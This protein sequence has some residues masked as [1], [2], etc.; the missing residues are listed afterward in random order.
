MTTVL[1]PRFI[2][3][4]FLGW[5]SILYTKFLDPDYAGRWLR[6]L[7]LFFHTLSLKA[8]LAIDWVERLEQETEY[9]EYTE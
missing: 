4:S 6:S 9:S 5:T 1:D 2:L 7:I 3:P 8:K